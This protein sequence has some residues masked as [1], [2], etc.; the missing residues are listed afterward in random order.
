MIKI[1]DYSI[2]KRFNEIKKTFG[3]NNTMCYSTANEMFSKMSSVSKRCSKSHHD[4]IILKA[5][6][7]HLY[8]LIPSITSIELNITTSLSPKKSQKN[9]DIR[10]KYNI[11]STFWVPRILNHSFNIII[12]PKKI[13]ISQSWY[14]IMNY[15]VI[16]ELSHKS[17]LIWLDDFR[18]KIKNYKNDPIAVFDLFK[19]PHSKI[20]NDI[21]NMFK[22]AKDSKKSIKFN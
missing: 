20:D 6:M 13:I 3:K 8:K 19:F 17:F 4:T 5:S 10:K 22:Y 14:K 1:N 9:I 15:K 11:K 2:E 21:K 7:S 18:S 16:Y 12:T